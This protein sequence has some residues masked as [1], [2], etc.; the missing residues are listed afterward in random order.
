MRTITAIE[1]QRGDRQ[2]VNV[3]LD[4]CYAFSLDVALALKANLC[5]GQSL[6]D[7]EIAHLGQQD[8][9]QRGYDAAVRFLGYRP[10][11]SAEVR[12]RLRQRGFSDET[13]DEVL[14]KLVEGRLVDDSA[15][16]KY[17]VEN[18]RTFKPCGGRL[19]GLELRQ[20]G[21]D[22][23]TIRETVGEVDEEAA[24][25]NA[26]KKKSRSLTGCD[27][28]QFRQRL[29]AFLQRRGFDYED[30]TRVTA[31]LWDEREDDEQQ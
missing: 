28:R 27:E 5:V 20:K 9:A 21:V 7:E 15:F 19:L 29:G 18:R 16:V 8:E 4:G 13:A 3:H 24:A 22:A 6:A 14:Q 23:E 25:Y 11:S 2:R 10:R 17:W 26:G 31:R 1:A 12:R 30:A